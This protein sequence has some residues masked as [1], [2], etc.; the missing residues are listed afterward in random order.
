MFHTPGCHVIDDVMVMLVLCTIPL[1]S[2]LRPQ[3]AIMLDGC[4]TDS[5]D[6]R[7]SFYLNFICHTSYSLTLA[8]CRSVTIL[9]VLPTW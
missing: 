8:V 4:A 7:R 2:P 3:I 9:L 1:R 5:L 6:W